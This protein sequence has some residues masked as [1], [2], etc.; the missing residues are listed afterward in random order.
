MKWGEL[1]L[2][3]LLGAGGLSGLVALFYRRRED[4]GAVVV[5]TASKALVVLQASRDQIQED[6]DRERTLRLLAERER[7]GERAKN[8]AL[9]L[10]IRRLQRVEE[11]S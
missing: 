3:L 5:D 9:R 2:K 8:E 1:A 10:V 11:E 6:F 4:S 7:D